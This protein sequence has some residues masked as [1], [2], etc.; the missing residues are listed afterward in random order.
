[1]TSVQVFI[2]TCP[3]WEKDLLSTS[4]DDLPCKRIYLSGMNACMSLSWSDP[5]GKH[6]SR[7]SWGL[8]A[9]PCSLPRQVLEKKEEGEQHGNVPHLFPRPGTASLG[10]QCGGCP[11]VPSAPGAGVVGASFKVLHG[12]E[13]PPLPSPP[14]TLGT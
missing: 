10:K 2:Q 11:V 1:M 5:G 9:L 3:F 7:D 14:P 12:V 8:G 13:A 4:L 6:S